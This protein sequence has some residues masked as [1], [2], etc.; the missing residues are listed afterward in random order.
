MFTRDGGVHAAAALGAVGVVLGLGGCAAKVTREEFNTQVAKLR[1]E[2]QAGDRQ[3]AVRVDSTNQ[4]V[5]DH[6]RRLDALEKE[7]QAFRS[8]Y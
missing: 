3:I 5:A 7:L 6:A 2:A 4:A 1:E 8:E